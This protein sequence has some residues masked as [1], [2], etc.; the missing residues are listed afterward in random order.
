MRYLWRL[1][2]VVAAVVTRLAA[3]SASPAPAA[4]SPEEEMLRKFYA[5]TLT[6]GAAHENLSVLVTKFPGRLSGSKS[7]EGAVAWGEQTL[8][9]LGLDRVYKQ[10]V[11][12]PHWERGEKE[13]VMML[14]ATGAEM[15]S[16]VALGGSVPTPKL[17]LHGEVIEVKSLDE[18][19]VLGS[20]K[21]TGKIVFFNRPMD[22]TVINPHTAYGAAGDQRNLGPA[23]AASLGAIGALTRSLT[24]ARD[25]L[26]HTGAT[27]YKPNG[28]NIPAAALSTRSADKL[29]AALAGGATV[30]V[31]MKISSQ[32]LP[33]A[34][35]HNV[36][37]EIRGSE[38]P[39]R[40]IL[41]GGH[42]D[43]WD[44]APGAHDDGAGVVQSIEVLRLFKA[45]GIIP[46]HTLRCVLFTAE[47]NGLAGALKYAELAK[48]AGEK[49]VLAIETDSGGF[50]PR[51][52]VLAST[53]GRAHEK[54]A[55]WRPL[56]EPYGIQSFS[57]GRGGADVA[58][59]MLQGATVG[60]L[61]PES[62]RYFDIHHTTAD[63]LDKVNAREL[64]IGAASLAALIW[65]VDTQGL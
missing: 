46:R 42:L 56:F 18:L 50:Q 41:V 27:A 40:I 15:L 65:L 47:E 24:H 52:F 21:L 26:P 13:A 61:A 63:S 59:L 51:A 19:V 22:P 48:A 32:W 28:P 20:A 55:R 31:T 7:L 9:A 29:S 6:H 37:G 49:H 35:S 45:L 11:M 44:I 64:H 43:S 16:A 54:A 1:L 60:S 23:A 53:Q 33:D 3:Q 58:P 17:G 39:D 38:F 57:Q 4:S 10:D 36:I 12:V 25:D 30:R 34:P 14:N 8:N 2:F 5:E 62:Q